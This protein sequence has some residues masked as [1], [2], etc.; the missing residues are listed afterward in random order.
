MIIKLFGLELHF[1]AW[2]AIISIIIWLVN[3]IKSFGED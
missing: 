3:E 1:I 2:L